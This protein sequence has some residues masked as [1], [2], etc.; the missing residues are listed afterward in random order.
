MLN[1]NK[2]KW[3]I[4]YDSSTHCLQIPSLFFP[5]LLTKRALST[6]LWFNSCFAKISFLLLCSYKKRYTPHYFLQPL[7]V[8][9]SYIIAQNCTNYQLT[10]EIIYIRYIYTSNI[11]GRDA[12]CCFPCYWFHHC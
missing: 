12:A 10:H 7:K 4:T 3:V 6:A 8:C 2:R 5:F 9:V 1:I 11:W